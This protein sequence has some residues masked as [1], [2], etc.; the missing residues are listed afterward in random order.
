MWSLARRSADRLAQQFAVANPASARVYVLE[1][2]STYTQYQVVLAELRFKVAGAWLT[3]HGTAQRNLVAATSG[4]VQG[5]G[6]AGGGA[7][8]EAMDGDNTTA[9]DSAADRASPA[10]GEH[11]PKY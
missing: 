4:S 3:N 8:W 5:A 7:G 6:V 11:M 10:T 9:W 2:S 1:V